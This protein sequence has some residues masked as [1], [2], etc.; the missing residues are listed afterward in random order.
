MSDHSGIVAAVVSWVTPSLGVDRL[1][2]GKQWQK[3]LAESKSQSGK[4]T[5]RIA[6]ANM[7]QEEAKTCGREPECDCIMIA[8]TM[9]NN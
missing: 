3:N 9:L 4:G 7:S 2:A 1:K 6:H 5:G 8:Q